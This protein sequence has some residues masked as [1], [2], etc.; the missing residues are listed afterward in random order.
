MKNR[1]VVTLTLV[2]LI[3]AI[4]IPAAYAQNTCTVRGQVIGEDGKPMVGILVYY[5]SD[6][7]GRKYQ[8]KTDKSGN[9]YSIAVAPGKYKITL[10]AADGKPLYPD[11]YVTT[12][13]TIQREVNVGDIDLKKAREES[14][15]NLSAEEKAKIEHAKNENAKIGQL[16]EKLTLSAQQEKA[17]Q[18]EDAVKTMEDAAALDQTHDVVFGAL[19]NA[20]LSAGKHNSDQAAAK[21]EFTK[22]ADA[23]TKALALKS[24]GAYYNNMG[25]A[26]ARMGQTKEALDAY[27]KAA[28]SDPTDAA[29]YYFNLGAVLTNS[30]KADEANVAFDKAIAADP[31]KADAYYQKAINLM[32][33]ATVDASG[34][35]T[36]PPEVAAGLNKYLELAPEGPYAQ[37]A[38]EMLAS[39]GAKVETSFGKAGAGKKKK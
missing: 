5:V 35:V 36:A 21:A 7:T 18:Y 13:V 30:G 32:G 12:V 14:L 15:G 29:K 33:K 34:K 16:N 38:K 4:F 17:G 3:A 25:E 20:Y 39:L 11:Y 2:A 22:A 8:L 10:L 19:G 28:E 27:T 6:E 37:T 26:Y 31:T 24:T 1:F 9:Y 23:Y